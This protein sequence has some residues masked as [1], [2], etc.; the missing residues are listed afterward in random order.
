MKFFEI[1]AQA[2]RGNS[3]TKQQKITRADHKVETIDMRVSRVDRCYDDFYLYKREEQPARLNAGH[4]TSQ[5]STIDGWLGHIWDG[6]S[7]THSK[8][9][10]PDKMEGPD[11][12]FVLTNGQARVLCVVQ[13]RLPN[14]TSIE[15]IH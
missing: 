15:S 8:F 2:K 10:F 13:V 9:L 12:M 5:T 14:L 4:L 1:L 11:L 3:V 6:K 7:S